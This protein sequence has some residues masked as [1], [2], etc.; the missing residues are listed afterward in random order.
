MVLVIVK[1]LPK[2]ALLLGFWQ[3]WVFHAKFEIRNSL[4][5]LC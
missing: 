2:A 5:Q 3:K 4:E 1:Q